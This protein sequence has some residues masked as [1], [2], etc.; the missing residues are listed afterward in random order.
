[1]MSTSNGFNPQAEQHLMLAY[2]ADLELEVDRL[3]KHSQFLQQ[4]ARHTVEHVQRT[5]RDFVQSEA[6]EKP[7]ADISAAI[8]RFEVILKDGYEPTG[9]H[10]SHDQVVAIALRPLIEQTFRWQQRLLEAPDATLHLELSREHVDWFPARLRHILDNLISNALRYRDPMKG[11]A[12]VSLSLA[13]SADGYQL[14]VSD[15]GVGMPWAKR[16]EAFELYHRA[17]PARATGVGVGIAVVKLLLEQSGGSL[18]VESGDGQGTS[19]VAVLPYYA[20]E[21]YL[22]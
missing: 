4:A 22:N 17:G 21:D 14:R 9:Y 20:A 12:R 13:R 7:V 6:N 19:F 1:M 16:A 2:V 15:N 11:E 10:P 18:T 3:R 5:C 8:D